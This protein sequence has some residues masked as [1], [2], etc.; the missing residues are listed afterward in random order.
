[1]GIYLPGKCY[2][3]ITKALGIHRDVVIAL[4]GNVEVYLLAKLAGSLP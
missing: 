1:M 3:A 2:R 4:S